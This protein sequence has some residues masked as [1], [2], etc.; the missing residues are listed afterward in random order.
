MC[1]IIDGM[2]TPAHMDLGR[3]QNE[4][5]IR[6]DDPAY[7]R[8]EQ[9]L[10]EAANRRVSI[11]FEL[12]RHELGELPAHIDLG[13]LRTAHLSGNTGLLLNAPIKIIH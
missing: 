7:V 10:I 3:H 13:C 1:I 4:L 11:L 2:D 12:G 6:F 8:A 9:V 5:T